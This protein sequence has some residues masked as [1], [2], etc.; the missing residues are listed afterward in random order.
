MNPVNYWQIT[1]L[2]VHVHVGI[3]QKNIIAVISSFL[4]LIPTIPGFRDDLL[5]PLLTSL[6]SKDNL[7]F[8]C[9]GLEPSSS[10][11]EHCTS[12]PT[13][14]NLASSGKL[15]VC[16]HRGQHRKIRITFEPEHDLAFKCHYDRI[17]I[18]I[19]DASFLKYHT[20]EI[21]ITIFVQ[22]CT[23]IHVRAKVFCFSL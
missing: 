11:T 15:A 7:I 21:M 14:K 22:N 6:G 16:K 5:N 8:F 1:V 19:H 2:H 3:K 12:V 18:D 20:G 17:F 9:P 13:V 23:N 4:I 10:N